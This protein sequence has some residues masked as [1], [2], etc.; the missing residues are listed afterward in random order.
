[1]F[2]QAV[3]SRAVKKVPAGGAMWRLR[4]LVAM[5]HSNLRIARALGVHKDA[6]NRLVAGDVE[7]VSDRRFRD[8]HYLWEAWWDKRP[9]ERNHHE[10][11]AASKAR[12]KAQARKWPTPVNLDE[13]HLDELGYR[14]TAHWHP[15][16]GAGI[17]DDYPLGVRQV[18]AL[19]RFVSWAWTRNARRLSSLCRRSSTSWRSTGPTPAGAIRSRC[20]ISCRREGSDYAPE[21]GVPAVRAPR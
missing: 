13:D 2:M 3:Q 15:A 14:P 8:V 18:A 6:V 1:M 10:R 9:P 20:A 7:F 16:T 19:W 17:A 5:G 12:H 4:S 11:I 21:K